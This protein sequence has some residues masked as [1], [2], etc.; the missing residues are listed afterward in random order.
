MKTQLL[1]L[2]TV[3]LTSLS[4]LG[5]VNAD[6]AK[7]TNPTN[8]HTYQ[9]F[10]TQQKTWVNAK[11]ACASIGGYL[12]TVTSAAE[13]TF[14]T[15]LANDN[16]NALGIWLGGTDEAQEGSWKWV[17]GETWSYIAWS[18]GEPNNAGNEDYIYSVNGKWNDLANNPYSLP[19]VCEWDAIQYIDF[20]AIPDVTGDG[21]SDIALLG[22]LSGSSYLRTFNGTT[23]KFIKEVQISPSSQVLPKSLSVV[24]DANTNNYKEIGVLYSGR[25]GDGVLLYDSLTVTWVKN[26]VLT[27]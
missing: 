9:W 15:T 16:N 10:G 11:S 23:G 27:N 21:K 12:A 13:N 24:D 8:N 3:A 2:S 25:Y 17:N 26:I 1:Y 7:V 18:A 22:T 20:T 19:Y 6:S 4:L 14:V 5:T